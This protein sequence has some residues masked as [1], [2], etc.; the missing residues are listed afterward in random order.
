MND[1][2]ENQAGLARP[3][4]TQRPV[5][6]AQR[7]RQGVARHKVRYVLGFGLVGVIIAFVAV[8]LLYFGTHMAG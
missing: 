4:S 3:A 6:P 2:D 8:H 7:A 5:V 1:R